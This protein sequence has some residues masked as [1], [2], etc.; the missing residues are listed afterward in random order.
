M[1]S[2]SESAA[3]N[4]RLGNQLRLCR[5]DAAALAAA[6][7]HKLRTRT[8]ATQPEARLY[9][10]QQ[11]TMDKQQQQQQQQGHTRRSSI[12]LCI[13]LLYCS[14][15]CMTQLVSCIHPQPFKQIERKGGRFNGILKPTKHGCIPWPTP[16]QPQVSAQNYLGPH[17]L[18]PHTD[19]PPSM[20]HSATVRAQGGW[21]RWGGGLWWL[22]QQ[23]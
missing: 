19:A 20:Q 22:Q 11:S 23:Q 5:H 18:A 4:A 6:V 21:P 9:I 14:C 12:C 3:T 10:L 17:T 2:A 15:E 13:P 1:R 8:W 7:T 16:P